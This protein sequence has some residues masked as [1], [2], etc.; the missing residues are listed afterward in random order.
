MFVLRVMM[1]CSACVFVCTLSCV[2]WWVVLVDISRKHHFTICR[3]TSDILFDM[4]GRA[5]WKRVRQGR[6]TGA[7][8]A[9]GVVRGG[10][11]A[12]LAA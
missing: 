4:L 12:G 9:R 8:G 11:D 3:Q 10:R 6:R 7:V 2:R 5:G 1:D